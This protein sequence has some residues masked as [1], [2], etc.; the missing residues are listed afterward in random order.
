MT[1]FV[2]T[3]GEIVVTAS[4]GAASAPGGTAIVG[5]MALDVATV[6]G[7][8]SRAVGQQALA[9]GYD[10]EDPAEKLFI[11]S[12]VNAGTALSGGAKLA[13]M[14]DVSRLTQQLVRGATWKKLLDSSLL[15]RLYKQVLAR[16]VVRTTKQGLGK[17]VPVVGILISGGFNWA[18][19]E[20]VT[21]AAHVA[22]RRR[23]LLEKYP[24]LADGD[25]P[26][27]ETV[28]EVPDEEDEVI[29]VLEDLAGLGG[30][31][32]S[33]DHGVDPEETPD[34]DPHATSGT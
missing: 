24:H 32:L 4:G 1:S 25:A 14:A 33:T 9:Y 19:L 23:F 3:G 28:G 31:D 16:F 27:L 11:L 2:I 26:E 6:M 29:S 5:A 20:Q 12:V 18:T 15:A 10:P 21:D 13:A 8:M 17:L 30:P 34:A 7:L 22:Y